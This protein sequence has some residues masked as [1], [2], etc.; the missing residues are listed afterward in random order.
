MLRLAQLRT[1]T[2]TV[3][4]P[5]LARIRTD[6]HATNRYVQRGQVAL[7]FTLVAALAGVIGAARPVT[8][9][10]LGHQWLGVEPILRLLAAAAMFQT[11][12]YVG[13]WIYLAHGLTVQLLRYTM[14]TAVLQVTCILVGSAFGLVGVA[15]GYVVATALE[16]PIS[17]WWLSRITQISAAPLYRGA[18][19][20]LSL[21]AVVGGVSFGACQLSATLPSGWQL[22]IACVAAAVVYA[23]VTTLVPPL[24]RDVA[25]LLSLA[26][27]SFRRN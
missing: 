25:G 22:T 19:R 3:A 20:I 27:K 24:R 15:W 1:P 2:T 11:L 18:A 12:A 6:R 7:G 21:C 8:E 9:V 17:L 10:F 14:V 23:V 16:W 5:V 4:L 26:R 13:Y